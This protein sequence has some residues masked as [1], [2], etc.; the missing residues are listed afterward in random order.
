MNDDDQVFTLHRVANSNLNLSI[1]MCSSATA[2]MT[3][4]NTYIQD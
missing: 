4:F 2:T 3:Y 1:R